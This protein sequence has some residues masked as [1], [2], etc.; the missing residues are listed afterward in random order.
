MRAKDYWDQRFEYMILAGELSVVDYET[1]LIQAYDLALI[2]IRKEIESFFQKYAKENKIPYEE[3]RRRLNSQELKSYQVLLREWYAMAQQMG[4]SKEFSA[5]LQ[6]L[7]KKVYITRLE[8]LES[9]IRYQIERVKAEQ[10]S[11]TQA[12]METNYLASYYTNY[13]N[14][15]Q[16]IEVAVKFDAIDARGVEKAVKTR[17]DGKNYSD[18]IWAD[19]D[20][21]VKTIQTVLPRSFSM[22]LNANTLGDIIAKQ[23]NVSKSKGRA[24]ARTEIN[25]LCNQSALDAYKSCGVEKYQ[26]LATLDMRTSEICRGLD[27]F[28]GKVSQASVNVNYPPMHVNCRSTTIPY[29]EDDAATERIAKDENGK[30]IKVPR[31][32]TQEEWIKQYAPDDQKDRLLGFTKKYRPK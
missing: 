19:K 5:Y 23:L 27:G 21:L 17:W 26:F 16:G 25:N 10:H 22:G 2:S 32:M 11:S 18:R 3:A 24:L 20:L 30:N 14:I 4:L 7:G 6:A 28:I 1:R 8:S 15:A 9:S 13:F 12:L 31:K 29:F